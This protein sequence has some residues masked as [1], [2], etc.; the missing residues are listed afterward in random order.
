[1]N[2]KP[3]M[4]EFTLDIPLFKIHWS[5]ED[6]IRVE[7]VIR[8]GKYWCIGPEIEELEEN[9]ANYL[10]LKHCVLF[11]SGGSA[12]H[13]LMESYNFSK[14]DEIIVPS[15]TFIG[16]AYAPLYVGSRPVFADVEEQTF[17]LDVED[18]KQ[19]ITPKTKAII[20]IH[21]GGMPC[22]IGAL[23][24]LAKDHNL[25]LIEDAAESF[26][27]KFKN[28]LT[29][30]FGE[31]AILSFCQNKIFTTSEGGAIVTDNSE[32]MERI[33]LFRSYG[34]ITSGDYFSNSGDIDYVERGYNLRMSSILAALG[35]SQLKRVDRLI[36]MRRKNAHYLNKR[37]SEVD[38]ITL[39]IP[40]TSEFYCVYQMYTIRVKE[41]RKK[42]DEL[43][44]YLK[45]K[46]ITSRV[47]FDPAHKFTI[48]QDLGFGA[49]KLPTTELLSSE[50][51]TLPMYP[52]MTN[53]ELDYISE[54]VIE[55]F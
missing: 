35:I 33:R 13:A 5:E 50:V 32:L 47:Y 7:K 49:I 17:G 11:N 19:K 12:L 15:F 45:N 20:P 28:N 22:Q 44:H 38:E 42:R 27:A 53:D 34:R 6:I 41:G 39:P 30:K 40:P 3:E 31:S 29:G 9:I 36:N 24:D 48:F 18:V 2:Q 52:H 37:L 14:G 8:S 10:G 1:M 21:Y 51:L 46:G 25:I 4:G 54:A 26:G 23:E 16:T 43:M 55:F